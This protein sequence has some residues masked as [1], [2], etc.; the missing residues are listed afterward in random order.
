MAM[1]K[2]II[3]ILRIASPQSLPLCI[4]ALKAITIPHNVWPVHHRVNL[5]NQCL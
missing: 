5:T 1:Q 2:Q 4:Y 3:N